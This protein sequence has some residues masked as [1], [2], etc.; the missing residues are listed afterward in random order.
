[1]RLLVQSLSTGLFLVPDLDD[2]S[3]VW[4]AHL[5]EAGGGVTT[6]PEMASQLLHDNCEPEDRAVVVDLDRLGTAEDYDL[7]PAPVALRSG[8]AGAGALCVHPDGN[9]GDNDFF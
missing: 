2:G 6:D 8:V 5:R 1:M 3:P 7:A 9:H 4:V